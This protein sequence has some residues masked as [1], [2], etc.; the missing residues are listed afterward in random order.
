MNKVVPINVDRNVSPAY[1]RELTDAGKLL[2]T[3]VFYTFQGEGPFAGQP[4]VFIRLAGCNIG[5]K[6]ECP[7]CDTFFSVGAGIPMTVDQLLDEV[8]RLW[9]GGYGSG[10]PP[11]VVVTGG[12]PLLQWPTLYQ[13][14]NELHRQ[15][16][17]IAVQVETN[18]MY[19]R[20]HHLEAELEHWPVRDLLVFVVSPKIAKTGR[21]VLPPEEVLA[22]PKPVYLK[23]VVTADAS[24]PYH[25][26]P[27][28]ELAAHRVDADLIYVSGMTDYTDTDTALPDA[29]VSLLVNFS[30]EARLRT[31]LNWQYAARTALRHGFNVS[32]QTHLLTG[33]Q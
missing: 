7:F 17:G 29:P 19:L 5:A 11:L 32:L 14:V 21:Y 15:A 26:L 31:A 12:E 18:G 20:G 22:G 27:L 3:S 4:A 9:P 25:E 33:V 6:E 30:E 23:F 2:V 8:A 24:S 10:R 1:Y 28:A 16:E 13:F